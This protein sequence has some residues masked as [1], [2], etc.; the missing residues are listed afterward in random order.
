MELYYVVNEKIK[1]SIFHNLLNLRE[2]VGR[3]ESDDNG[4]D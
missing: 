2:A 4:R 3:P 1:F